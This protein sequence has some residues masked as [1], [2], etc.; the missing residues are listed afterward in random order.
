[1]AL[2]I[3]LAAEAD[4][5]RIAAIHMAA[6]ADNPM[7]HAQFPTP[8]LRDKLKTCIA[9]KAVL[10]IRDPKTAVLVVRDQNEIIS[11]AKWHLPVLDSEKYEEPPWP[12]PEGT[13]FAILDKWVE[14]VEAAQ[15]KVLGASPCYRKCR[16]DPFTAHPLLHLVPPFPEALQDIYGYACRTLTCISGFFFIE[17]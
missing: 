2:T 13:N 7:L 12:W 14:K 10:D 11:F 15:Q 3:S 6:F 1:M 8:A 16:E 17:S 5:D 9:E 4:A